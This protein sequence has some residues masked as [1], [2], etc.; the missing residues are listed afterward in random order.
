VLV[1]EVTANVNIQTVPPSADVYIRPADQSIRE[2]LKLG[3]SNLLGYRVPLGN[4][5]WKVVKDG[6]QAAFA[7]K[8]IM[9]STKEV[10]FQ[11]DENPGESATSMVRICPGKPVNIPGLLQVTDEL[12]EF[13]F[14]RFE[15]TNA[16]FQEF[17]D[18]GGYQNRK[19]WPDE[20]WEN[21]IRIPF[22]EA[23]KRFCDDGGHLGPATWV[24]GRYPA[25]EGNLPVRG[26]SWYE[27]SAYAKSRGM[28]LPTIF[29]WFAAAGGDQA[30]IVPHSNLGNRYH[31]PRA[32]GECQG[33]GEYGTFD[34]A[35]NVKE[36]C[37][38]GAGEDQKYILGG[39]WQDPEYMFSGFDAQ[40]PLAR[41]DDFGF[42][43]MKWSSR[44][45][46]EQW[47][48]DVILHRRDYRNETP[49]SDEEFEELVTNYEYTR[50]KPLNGTVGDTRTI[51]AHTGSR[52]TRQ[53]VFFD[54]AYPCEEQVSGYLFLP[55]PD[56]ASKPYQAVIYFPG[57]YAVTSKLA[58]PPEDHAAEW[59]TP[60]VDN[61]RAVFYPFYWGTY[62]RNR[63]WLESVYPEMTNTYRTAVIHIAQDFSRSIDYLVAR[64]DIDG[65]RLGYY[66]YSWGSAL[67]PI[68]LATDDRMKA[69]ILN[70]GGF[71]QQPC[72]PEV[73]PL[74]FVSR[75]KTP[76]LMLNGSHDAIFPEELSQKPMFE[77]FDLDHNH[78]KHLILGKRGHAL[79]LI[80]GTNEAIRWL[81]QMLGPVRK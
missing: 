25:G 31:G 33:I 37:T 19:H 59:A 9:T 40:S 77:L 46:Q 53:H 69:A 17:V 13:A 20:F 16:R 63:G 32:V 10:S 38:N 26:V 73:D 74:H 78:K 51:E 34:M 35:G 49:C 48:G 8:P 81:D 66:G 56:V 76:V 71:S 52:Y 54:A 75:V 79:P 21:G 65:E 7:L 58:A 1:D 62:A 4:L 27:A 12:D 67:A 6:Y 42:R 41:R 44:T 68:L 47:M 39:S 57:G 30:L 70:N 2:W 64:D 18:E 24:N 80:E 50:S 72:D 5:Q 45:N 29:H 36:W 61:G 3:R 15:V 28:S 43:V 23:M 60:F 14:G 11:L 22:A 55:K